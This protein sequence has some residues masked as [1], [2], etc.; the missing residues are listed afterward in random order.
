MTDHE[1]RPAPII[2]NNPKPPEE[3]EE[4]F[5]DKKV[6]GI[7]TKLAGLHY[8]TAFEKAAMLQHHTDEAIRKV[9]EAAKEDGLRPVED[10][11]IQIRVSVMC[12][13]IP[14]ITTLVE[15]SDE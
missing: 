7:S 10:I 8:D 15:E 11:T 3:L 14:P 5:K 9:H 1:D 6:I 12:E 4:Y 13:P 2:T